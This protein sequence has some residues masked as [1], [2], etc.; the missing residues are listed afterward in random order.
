MAISCSPAERAT[1]EG[2]L[3]TNFPSTVMSAPSGVDLMSIEAV[4]D[5][6]GSAF[7]MFAASD[8]LSAEGVVLRDTRARRITSHAS[9]DAFLRKKILCLLKSIAPLLRKTA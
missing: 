4:V 6:G 5:C 7:G 9:L 3:P 2:V 8:C 1:V